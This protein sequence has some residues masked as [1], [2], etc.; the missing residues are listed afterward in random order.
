MARIGKAGTGFSSID[1]SKAVDTIAGIASRRKSSRRSSSKPKTSSVRL[2]GDTVFI[3]GKGFSVA[4]SLQ[5]EFIKSKTGGRG[6][7]AQTAIANATKIETQRRAT[8]KASLERALKLKQTQLQQIKNLNINEQEKRRLLNIKREEIARQQRLINIRASQNFQSDLKSGRTKGFSGTGLSPSELA[9]RSFLIK[10]GNVVER[11]QSSR[12]ELLNVI[13]P[14]LTTF[15]V[16]GSSVT[17]TEFQKMKSALTSNQFNT[18]IVPSEKTLIN[19]KIKE[20]KNKIINLKKITSLGSILRES[21][22]IINDKNTLKRK[23]ISLGAIP[24]TYTKRQAD[25]LTLGVITVGIKVKQKVSIANLEEQLEFRKINTGTATRKLKKDK[26]DYLRI[27]KEFNRKAINKTLN[28]G[29]DVKL[30]QAYNR[31][32]ISLTRSMFMKAPEQATNVLLGYFYLGV[33]LKGLGSKKGRTALR[34]SVKEIPS[35]VVDS[36]SKFGALA[37][38]NPEQAIAVIGVEIGSEILEDLLKVGL[39][40]LPFTTSILKTFRKAINIVDNLNPRIVRIV[41]NAIDLT[42]LGGRKVKA[43][44]KNL[45]L[46][47]G[48]VK[49]G[50]ESLAEATARGGKKTV[51]VSAQAMQLVGLIKRQKVIRK[52]IP[53]Q[54]Q[55]SKKLRDTLKIFDKG[56]LTVNEILQL[57]VD[58]R[59]ETAKLFKGVGQVKGVDLLERSSF[60]DPDKLLRKSRLGTPDERT[61]RGT[62]LDLFTGKATLF[63]KKSKPQILILEDFVESLPKIKEFATIRAKLKRSIVKG[64]DPNLTKLEL[65]KL[66]RWQVTPSGKLKP[67][68]S[69]TFSGGMEREVTIAPGEA[70]RRVRKIATLKIG[71]QR[72][73]IIAVKIVKGKAKVTIVKR[74]QDLINKIKKLELLKKKAKTQKSKLAIELKIKKEKLRLSNMEAKIK[75]ADIK[76]FF[77]D[78]RRRTSPTK[79]KAVITRGSVTQATVRTARRTVRPVKRKTTKRVTRKPVK[80]ITSKRKP[81]ARKPVK[82]AITKRKPTPRKPVKRTTPRTPNKRTTPSK[83][84]TPRGTPKTTPKKKKIIIPNNKKFSKRTLAKSTPVYYILVKRK[85][86]LVKLTQFPLTISDARDYLAYRIDNTLVRS[87]WFKPIGKAKKVVSLPKD[88]R[89]YFSKTNRKLRPYKIKF[90][91]KKEILNG[92]IE[93]SKYSLDTAREQAQLRTSKRKVVKRRT[94]TKTTKRR[95]KKKKK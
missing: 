89:G 45:K 20:I 41:D 62:L 12:I 59:K 91:Y 29:D 70:I 8:E 84:P 65:A 88:M 80:R 40:R 87:A 75:D 38:S 11:T 25:I 49:E 14:L 32:N 52:P 23:L 31:F 57:N 86:K 81:T 15:F 27:K 35:S 30:A 50:S 3:D 34:A 58:I 94:T 92:Y 36:L 63:S 17:Q 93:R 6:T 48:G 64:V 28:A 90:G 72:I 7:S 9:K 85:G 44:T 69:T 19:R 37:R 54:D 21:R 42:G 78:V 83:R 26:A 43:L 53:F 74:I 73:P 66:S 4:P 1:D 61:A 55:L 71:N 33:I 16:G 95:T 39:A 2:S 18:N 24:I 5:A 13:D 47:V 79:K 82:R 76:N 10:L 77:K 68:G 22:T 67:I 60:F 51:A 56:K 46:A